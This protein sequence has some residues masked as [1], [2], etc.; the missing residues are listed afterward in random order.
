[1]S[2]EKSNNALLKETKA[3]SST[4][5]HEKESKITMSKNKDD[6]DSKISAASTR[7]N[8]SVSN[9]VASPVISGTTIMEN[10]D[11]TTTTIAIGND[12]YTIGEIR[13]QNQSIVKSH[14]KNYI[15]GNYGNINELH[16]RKFF[17]CFS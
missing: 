16:S 10:E 6:L 13:F 5:R 2:E 4:A 17:Y 12:T 8:T 1:M 9:P 7:K 14:Y 15:A 3:S 11:A